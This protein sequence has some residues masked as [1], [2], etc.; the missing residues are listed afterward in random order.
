MNS[1]KKKN[2]VISIGL[3]TAWVCIIIILSAASS[4]DPNNI[5]TG[6]FWARLSGLLV[7]F[8][9]LLFLALR[10][11]NSIS[12]NEN[13]WYAFFATSNF[14][15]G[16]AGGLFYLTHNINFIGLHD[17]LPNLLLGVIMMTDL[18]LH[19]YIFKRNDSQN[20]VD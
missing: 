7:G 13:F 18:I 4:K 11:F 6:Y 2:V 5:S 19:D 20:R 15:V 3:V 17:L 10:I 14:I 8:G 9:G 1:K 16:L 12:R